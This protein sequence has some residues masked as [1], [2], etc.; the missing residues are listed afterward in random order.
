MEIGGSISI[1]GQLRDM[2]KFK[3]MSCFIMQESITQ[4]NLTVLEAMYFAADLKLGRSKSTPEK[5]AA[6]SRNLDLLL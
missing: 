6:V 5:R 3:K 4:P 1:N 2:D